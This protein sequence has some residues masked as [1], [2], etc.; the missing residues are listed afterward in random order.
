[1]DT[2]AQATPQLVGARVKQPCQF[3]SGSKDIVIAMIGRNEK[4][5]MSIERGMERLPKLLA[6]GTELAIETTII[7]GCGHWSAC[8]ICVSCLCPC[9][10]LQ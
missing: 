10:R 3:I 2:N 5:E 8:V 1:M 9:L 4:G 7:E 6:S